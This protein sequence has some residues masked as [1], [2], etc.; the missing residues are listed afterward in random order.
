M[1]NPDREAEN[2]TAAYDRYIASLFAPEDAALTDTLDAMQQGNLP[3]INVS[4]AEGKILQV[5]ALAVG[6]RRVLEIGTLGGFSGIHF[7][8][9]LP[10][11]G[12]LVTLELDPHHAD[13]ARK[14]FERANVQE[15]VEIHVGPAADTLDKL[16]AE[17]AEPFDVVYID[18]DKD[19]YVTYL[20][21]SLPLLR[22][23]GLLLADNALPNA[24]LTGE[25]AGA[26]RYNTAA[27]QTDG[28]TSVILPVLRDKGIDGLTVSVKA[29]R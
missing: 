13:V 22:E 11:G 27:A 1:S 7:A 15:K 10:D 29:A 24:V 9:V 12:K 14:N 21:K 20:Q 5:L 2:R 19:G 8:R 16:A 28:L 25:D 6:A 17:G 18:A 23:G 4:Y 3:S 26:K